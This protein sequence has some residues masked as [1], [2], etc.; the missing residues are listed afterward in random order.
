MK[1]LNKITSS[2]DVE[3]AAT[4]FSASLS[5]FKAGS[6][7]TH[8]PGYSVEGIQIMQLSDHPWLAL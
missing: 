1:N 4:S 8:M 3:V 6:A 2:E 7:I 5:P